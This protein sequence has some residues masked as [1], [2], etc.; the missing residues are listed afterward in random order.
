[1]KSNQSGSLSRA[2]FAARLHSLA[3]E[4]EGGILNIQGEALPLPEVFE[5]TQ[6]AT[7]TRNKAAYALKLAWVTVMPENRTAR[8]Q[9]RGRSRPRGEKKAAET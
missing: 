6:T 5:V 7:A 3:N 4:I 1:M 2:D 9:S 8:P